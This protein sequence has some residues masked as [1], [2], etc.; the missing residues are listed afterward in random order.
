MLGL[1]DV[2][3]DLQVLANPMGWL[4]IITM[5]T[6]VMYLVGPVRAVG[7]LR[8]HTEGHW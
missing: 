7:R 8:T 6:G 3:T 4:N 5:I 2:F 1:F